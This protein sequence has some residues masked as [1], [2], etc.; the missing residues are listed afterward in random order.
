MFA[1]YA[2]YANAPT[3]EKRHD[4]EIRHPR[5]PAIPKIGMTLSPFLLYRW[6]RPIIGQL[7]AD[8]YDFD[9]I[10]AHY[11]YPDG[12][13]AAMLGRRFN[14]PVVITG[15]GS[16]IN[17]IARYSIPGKLIRWAA[18]QASG[19]IAVSEGLAN[20]M[21]DLGIDRQKIR[22]LRNGVD[23]KMFRPGNRTEYQQLFGVESPVL[24]SAGNLIPLKGHDL[25][26]RALE[27][28]PGF[29]LIIVGAGPEEKRLRNLARELG[30]TDRI[31]FLGGVLHEDMCAIYNAA[32]ALVLASESE[33]WPNVLLESM[34]CGTPVISSEVSGAREAVS[35]AAAGLI[36]PERSAKGLAASIMELFESLPDRNAT[37][38]YAEK[39][40]WDKTTAGQL[41]L[42]MTVVR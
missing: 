12:V 19:V 41:D 10:D 17:V 23:L 33:G 9:L 29:R 22:V 38:K 8:G 6:V 30:L 15:R 13:A 40:S 7:Q 16:D 31:N 11:F 25:V 3:I 24:L 26:I 1:R 5:F 2:A 27:R 20:A 28:L 42:F 21:S 14:R 34:A 39:F 37:R 35:A 32:D 18:R 4:I 36:C